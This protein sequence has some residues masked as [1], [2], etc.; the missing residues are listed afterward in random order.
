M[1]LVYTALGVSDSANFYLDKAKSILTNR[2]DFY[3]I[4]VYLIEDAKILLQNKQY[5]AALKEI[6]EAISLAKREGFKEQLDQGYKI[7]SDI[8]KATGNHKEAFEAYLLHESYHDSI[9]NVDL[10]RKMENQRTEFEI[11]KR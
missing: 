9:T 2:K 11:S 10:V 5:Q 3:P 8:H 4:S 6:N 1:G 7:L